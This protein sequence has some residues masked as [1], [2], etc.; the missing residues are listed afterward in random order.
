MRLVG[1]KVVDL[2]DTDEFLKVV[3]CAFDRGSCLFKD[4]GIVPEMFRFNWDG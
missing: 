3:G 1:A 4:S 2:R